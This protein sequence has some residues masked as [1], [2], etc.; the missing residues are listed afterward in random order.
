M[1]TIYFMIPRYTFFTRT[2]SQRYKS[3]RSFARRFATIW[4]G[5]VSH[6]NFIVHDIRAIRF[7]RFLLD[8][9][10]ERHRSLYQINREQKINVIVNGQ[11]DNTTRTTIM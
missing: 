10:Y 11:H 2:I 1:P 6:A 8:E 3:I 5:L 9:S 7:S 4:R